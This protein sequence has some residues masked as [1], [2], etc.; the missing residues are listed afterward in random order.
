MENLAQTANIGCSSPY[1]VGKRSVMV[2][3]EN[4]NDAIEPLRMI[5]DK[6]L[7]LIKHLISVPG[8][9]CRLFRLMKC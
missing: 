9:D 7:T 1:L 5:N 4:T 2:P 3:E 8:Y 6:L